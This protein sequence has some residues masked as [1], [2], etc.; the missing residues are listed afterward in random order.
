MHKIKIFYFVRL[1]LT[2]RNLNKYFNKI[3]SLSNFFISF[4]YESCFRVFFQE[5]IHKV[6]H[7]FQ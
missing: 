5:T 6:I 4:D 3:N 2:K 1:T 7:S